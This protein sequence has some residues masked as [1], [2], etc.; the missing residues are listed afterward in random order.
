MKCLK[1]SVSWSN[2]SCLDIQQ[3][4]ILTG[5]TTV[6]KEGQLNIE[7]VRHNSKPF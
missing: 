5:V 2:I 4:P 1:N 3:P 6:A 7:R